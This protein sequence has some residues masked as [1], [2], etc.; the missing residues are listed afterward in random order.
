VYIPEGC[1]HGYQSLAART[2]V[3]YTIDRE[4]APGT[5]IVLAWDDPELNIPWP[6]PCTGISERDRH[7]LTL[8][9][10]RI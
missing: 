4:Y 6:L 7:G 2:D 8:A 1:A 5:E 3:N 10:A 9:A